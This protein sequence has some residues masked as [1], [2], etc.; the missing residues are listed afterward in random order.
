MV[1]RSATVPDAGTTLGPDADHPVTVAGLSG[2]PA[3]A[4]A[5]V[6]NVTVVGATADS[7]PTVFPGEPPRPNRT[8]TRCPER[9]KRTWSLS[10]SRRTER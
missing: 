6:L 8:S 4:S 2:I 5:V 10:D 7:Y 1:T 3:D 9:P